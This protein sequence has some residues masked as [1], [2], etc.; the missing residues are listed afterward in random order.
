MEIC[1]THL[2]IN[3]MLIK[4]TV[5]YLF[6]HSSWSK[7]IKSCNIICWQ[8]YKTREILKYYGWHIY[9][10]EGKAKKRK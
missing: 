9:L 3:E 1:L 8:G 7:L 4:I 10:L 5:R 2:A 6:A